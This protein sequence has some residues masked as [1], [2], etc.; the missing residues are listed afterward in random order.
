MAFFIGCFF[1]AW[2]GRKIG[3]GLSRSVLS[4]SSWAVCAVLCFAWALGVAYAL[5]LFI[6]ATEP[7]L[8]LKI[9]GY[10]AGTYIS[11]PNYGLI[12]ESSIPDSGLAR[13]VFIKGVPMVVFIAAS[14][15]FAFNVL[16]I[17]G[18]KRHARF[19]LPAVPAGCDR[20]GFGHPY[21]KTASYTGSPGSGRRSLRA[22]RRS[23]TAG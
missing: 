17:A 19:H 7:G 12:D 4:T 8:L 1:S 14:V 15:W 9:F 21:I 16:S 22:W 20:A 3:W 13:H 6:L 18:S 10:G 11:I 2:I 23:T 5:R